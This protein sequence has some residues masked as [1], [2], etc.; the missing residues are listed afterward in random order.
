LGGKDAGVLEYVIMEKMEKDQSPYLP[1]GR[2]PTT[3]DLIR[4]VDFQIMELISRTRRK[5]PES[6]VNENNV[7]DYIH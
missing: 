1:V 4:Y 3:R 5:I 2:K 6:Y 7:L